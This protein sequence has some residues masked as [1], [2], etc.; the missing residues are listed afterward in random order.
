MV[1]NE[2]ASKMNLRLSLQYQVISAGD[3]RARWIYLFVHQQ[4]RIF[5]LMLQKCLRK[6]FFSQ[7][8]PQTL[9]VRLFHHEVHIT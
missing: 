5:K 1:R 6:D 8:S 2:F 7:G 9:K 4:R 3:W